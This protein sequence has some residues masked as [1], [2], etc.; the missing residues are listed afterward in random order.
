MKPFLFLSARP[1]V[2][3]VGPEYE[4]V[5]RGMG[6]D[7]GRLE[8]LRLDVE[9]LGDLRLDDVAGVIVGGSPYNVTAPEA[10]KQRAQV[11]PR[12]GGLDAPVHRLRIRKR[13]LVEG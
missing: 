6:I 9:A 13:L 10:H 8:H 11:V 4:A 2:E 12:V 5:R 3:A 1:E 7:A